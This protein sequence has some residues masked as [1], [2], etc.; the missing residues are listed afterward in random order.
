MKNRTKFTALITLLLLVLQL[1]VPLSAHAALDMRTGPDGLSLIERYEGYSDQRYELNGKWYIGYGT[2]CAA[3]AYPD[4]ITR[5]EAEE[6]LREALGKCESS[7]NSFCDRS[8][9]TPTQEQFDALVSFTFTLGDGWLSGTSD[10]V[11]IVRGDRS[12]TRL[13]TARA[14]GV[15]CHI[16]GKANTM[17]AQRRL[18]EAALYLDGNLAAAKEEFA[19]LIIQKEDGV[20]YET[21]FSV[22]QRG[23]T[24]DSFPEM[25]KKDHK[26]TGLRTKDGQL[27]KLGDAVTGNMVTKAE[28]E[29]VASA[30]PST[31]TT[32]ATPTTPVTPV[33]SGYSDVRPEDWFYSYVTDLSAAGVINGRGNGVFAPKDSVTVGETLKLVLLATGNSEQKATGKHWAS[34][35]AQ[36][37][38]SKGYIDAA[39]LSDLNAV[40]PRI[41][42]ARLA[43]KAMGLKASSAATPFSDANDGYLTAL[44]EAG[45]LTGSFQNGVRVYLPGDGISRAEISAVIWRINHAAVQRTAPAEEKPA[46][47]MPAQETPAE[48]E[49]PEDTTPKIIYN[50]TELPILEGVPVNSYDKNAFSR[51]GSVMTYSEPGVTTRLGIDVSRYQEE[52]DWEAV[53]KSGVEF[54]IIRVGGRYWSSGEIYADARF[55]EYLEGA[56]AAGLDVGVYFYSQAITAAEAREEADYVL[57]MIRGAEINAPVVFD[58]ELTGSST[59]RTNGIKTD[60]LCACAR[61]FCDRVSQAGYHPMI[62][63]N[64]YAGYMKY[65]LS[66]IGDY[67][68]WFAEYDLDA[69]T[70]YY[71]FQ[72]W[73]YTSK[74]YVDGIKGKVDMNLWF[75]R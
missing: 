57:R 68:L 28:W 41:E 2:A 52:I 17:L 10:L 61:A 32:P 21:D 15:W 9:L 64:K 36:L 51:R 22:Y 56:S 45:I 70:F 49:Q 8:G 67:D 5:A 4:G 75:I 60:V 44:Y 25:T 26:L 23:G 74:G 30:A 72:M 18:E 20:T 35:Y 6:L 31:P 19:Y 40:M 14:F 33:T 38:Q 42:V 66:Q 50:N 62:Y 3:D 73:Q 13:E 43:A 16:G 53:K 1:A 46:E 29:K 48:A 12:A 24:Y 34:G 27:I 7:I 55:E 69:P 71:D 54:V 37:A 39:L 11:Q 58:W 63:I 47:Q 65:D 59:A